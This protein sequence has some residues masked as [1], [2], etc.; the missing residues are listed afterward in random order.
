MRKGTFEDSSAFTKLCI[1]FMFFLCGSIISIIPFVLQQSFSNGAQNAIS[2]R[3]TILIQDIF[4][5]ILPALAA[6]F[7]IWRSSTKKTL[8]LNMPSLST[9][10]WGVLAIVSIGPFIDFIG[11]WNQGL[12]LPE[13]MHSIEQWMIDSEKTAEVMLNNII[14]TTTWGGYISN[15]FLIAIMAGISEEL[16]FRGVLQK[17][18][19]SWTRNIHIG[20]LVTAVIFSA[21]HFQFF[22]FFPRV[23]L[24][25][26]LG[27]L[28]IYS[29][30]L[31][32]PVIA[33]TINNALTV[34]FTPSTFTKG[35]HFI[36]STAKIE[37]NC[38]YVIIG[39]SLFTLSMWKLYKHYHN[40]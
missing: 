32:V 18:F 7:Y 23:I 1:L 22:G 36:E 40:R 38:W 37:N 17:I 33:H 35:N 24:G 9:I 31:W 21:I 11:T 10:L 3:I 39:L 12:H 19:I 15:I 8:Q 26:I 5:F 4:I 6:Q 28:Y 30:S 20:I 29:K 25:V 2:I 34:V 13:S 14:N 16:L 27:Y